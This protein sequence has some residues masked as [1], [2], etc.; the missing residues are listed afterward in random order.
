MGVGGDSGSNAFSSSRSAIDV[1]SSAPSPLRVCR[2]SPVAGRR[3]HAQGPPSLHAAVVHL[4]LSRRVPTLQRPATAVSADIPVRIAAAARVRGRPTGLRL[5]VAEEPHSTPQRRAEPPSRSR[6]D[7]NNACVRRCRAA[8]TT[9]TLACAQQQRS[10]PPLPSFP[11]AAERERPRLS[12]SHA[13]LALMHAHAFALTHALSGALPRTHAH[14]LALRRAPSHARTCALLLPH[15]SPP[16]LPPLSLS[17]PSL[18]SLSRHVPSLASPP[19]RLPS[20]L[21]SPSRSHNTK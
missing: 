6:P 14:A 12:T 20:R 16:L 18:A 17:F 15:L 11:R 19:S 8:R 13:A 7:N 9:T 5:S 10:R 2:P 1:G 4:L 3:V 21:L